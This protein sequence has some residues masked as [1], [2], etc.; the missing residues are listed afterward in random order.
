MRGSCWRVLVATRARHHEIDC[1]T[2]TVQYF[3]VSTLCKQRVRAN[4]QSSLP[5]SEAHDTELVVV[6]RSSNAAVVC[7]YHTLTAGAPH[8]EIRS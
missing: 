3:M 6:E 1:S 2:D 7:T 4:H 8:P 5:P